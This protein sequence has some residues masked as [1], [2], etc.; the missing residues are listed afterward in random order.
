MFLSE[1]LSPAETFQEML[2]RLE[3]TEEEYHM[4]LKEVEEA[5][6]LYSEF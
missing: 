1:I 5:K 3:M 4:Y 2:W 6:I